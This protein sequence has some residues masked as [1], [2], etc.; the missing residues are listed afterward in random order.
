MSKTLGRP[1]SSCSWSEVVLV[2]VVKVAQTEITKRHRDN[3]L[4]EAITKSNT[5]FFE[6]R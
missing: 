2:Q 4:N 6:R 3:V 5:G 1:V